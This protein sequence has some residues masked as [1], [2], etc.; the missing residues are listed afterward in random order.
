MVD[1]VDEEV[2]LAH[3]AHEVERVGR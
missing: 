3:A 2:E 1:P